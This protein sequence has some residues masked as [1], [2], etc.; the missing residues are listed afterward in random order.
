MNWIK[1]LW[2][3][4]VKKTSVSP[5]LVVAEEVKEESCGEVFRI[6]CLE[7]GVAPRA[8][9]KGNVV[10]LFEEWYKGPCT[11]PAIRLSIDAFRE[12]HPVA[13]AKLASGKF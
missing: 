3:K 5:T 4:L 9:D 2:N 10:A 13:N 12:S 6:I 8:I 11:R 1:T 7:A